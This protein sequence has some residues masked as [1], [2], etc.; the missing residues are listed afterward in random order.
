MEQKIIK[1]KYFQNIVLEKNVAVWEYLCPKS[2]LFELVLFPNLSS[3]LGFRNHVWEW[4]SLS[5]MLITI[6]WT[7]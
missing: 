7:S 6:D 3:E 2:T 4:F 1:F 5:H